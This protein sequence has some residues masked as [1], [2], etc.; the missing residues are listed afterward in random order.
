MSTA[1]VGSCTAFGDAPPGSSTVID[2]ASM[3]CCRINATSDTAARQQLNQHPS[4][5]LMPDDDPTFGF[6]TPPAALARALAEA[7]FYRSIDCSCKTPF[8]VQARRAKGFTSPGGK[9]DDI[10][11]VAA[12]VV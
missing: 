12:W 4:S 11:V 3:D 1:A 7:A 8:S 5:T 2:D 9:T 6:A 10:T